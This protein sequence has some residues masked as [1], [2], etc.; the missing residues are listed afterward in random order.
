ME[1]GKQG[2]FVFYLAA[3]DATNIKTSDTLVE[4]KN[5][6]YDTFDEL[7]NERDKI[8][9]IKFCN[10]KK[11]WSTESICSCRTF[12]KEFICKHILALAFYYRL[13]KCPQEGNNKTISPKPKRGRIA[14]AKKA[15]QKQ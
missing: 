11:K 5:K 1:I 12:Q 4:R 13:K 3:Y 2:E 10:V 14:L 6:S 9:N 8:L 15:L 7:K